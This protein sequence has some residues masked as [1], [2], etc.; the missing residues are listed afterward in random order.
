MNRFTEMIQISKNY[1]QGCKRRK[2]IALLHLVPHLHAV[3][4]AWENKD[5]VFEDLI[6]FPNSARE[7]VM[8]CEKKVKLLIEITRDPHS[9][10]YCVLWL[11]PV[12]RPWLHLEKFDRLQESIAS[13]AHIIRE[14]ILKTM[15]IMW[16]LSMNSLH[17]KWCS[18]M[19]SNCSL[20]KYD[21][22]FPC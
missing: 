6:K 1:L 22:S 8:F 5:D 17:M 12:F 9:L 2:K 7:K 13:C 3:N 16:T 14:I 15:L 19:H 21:N 11:D 10:D 4:K 20:I 18:L